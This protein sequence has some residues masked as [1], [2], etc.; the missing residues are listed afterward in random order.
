MN[1]MRCKPAD[2]KSWTAVRVRELRER[3][4]IAPFDPAL[5]RVETVTVDEAAARLGICV[6]SVHK[7]IRNRVLPATQLMHSAPWQIPVAALE[8]ETVTTGVRYIVGRRPK[9]YKR[10]QDD[11]PSNCPDYERK[12]ALCQIAPAMPAPKQSNEKPSALAYRACHH[13][14]LHIGVAG[15]NLLVLIIL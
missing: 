4:G 5:P 15:D 12:D 2:G 10:F 13:R 11:I 1:R 14:P 8:T 6:R 9:F 3:L 7:L